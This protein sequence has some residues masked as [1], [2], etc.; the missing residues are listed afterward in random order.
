MIV[1]PPKDRKI[2]DKLLFALVGFFG[3]GLYFLGLLLGLALIIF[4]KFG[5]NT[6]TII[7]HIFSYGFLAV[8]PKWWLKKRFS[9][10]E[11]DKKSMSESEAQ[12]RANLGESGSILPVLRDVIEHVRKL[13]SD[14]EYV[15]NYSNAVSNMRAKEEAIRSATVP[16]YDTT[17]KVN[18]VLSIPFVLYSY[19]LVK[20]E[21]FI[22]KQIKRLSKRKS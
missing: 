20:L 9:I 22:W 7:L 17:Q 16:F 18:N 19:G 15:R 14:P 11:Y 21:L 6:E 1:K 8:V 2:G 5:I 12:A 10:Y 13:R 4:P 3:H